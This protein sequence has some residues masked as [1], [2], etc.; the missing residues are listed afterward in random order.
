VAL[1]GSLGLC[2][3]LLQPLE[4]IEHGAWIHGQML[5]FGDV[6]PLGDYSS[7]HR[8]EAMAGYLDAR[9]VAHR[10]KGLVDR[11]VAYRAAR[12]QTGNT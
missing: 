6:Q 12:A 7:G 8:P 10:A 5:F 9:V 11:A 1:F 2:G 3:F 4:D